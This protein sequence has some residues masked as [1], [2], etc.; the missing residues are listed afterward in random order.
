MTGMLIRDVP[1]GVGQ[2]D[3]ASWFLLR[4]FSAIEAMTARITRTSVTSMQNL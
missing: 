1:D 2:G 3:E 4:R